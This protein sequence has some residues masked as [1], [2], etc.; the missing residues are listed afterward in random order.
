MENIT[1]SSKSEDNARDYIRKEGGLVGDEEVND[2]FFGEIN[3]K[4]TPHETRY[5]IGRLFYMM[6]RQRKGVQGMS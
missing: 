2:D 4:Y 1:T 6:K 3:E 5:Q